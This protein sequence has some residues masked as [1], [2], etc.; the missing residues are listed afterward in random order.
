MLHQ[1]L[2]FL[3]VQ[4]TSRAKTNKETTFSIT[5]NM[6]RLTSLPHVILVPNQALSPFSRYSFPIPLTVKSFSR[7]NLSTNLD[8]F[9]LILWLLTMSS[10]ISLS[11]NTMNQSLKSIAH[12]EPLRSSSFATIYQKENI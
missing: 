2:L 3:Y 4:R 11:P 5:Q 7:I 8:I 1:V 6:K 9:S 10:C 12:K